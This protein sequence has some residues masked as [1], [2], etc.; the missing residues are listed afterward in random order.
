MKQIL[1]ALLLVFPVLAFGQMQYIDYGDWV[2][3]LNLVNDLTGLEYIFAENTDW[4]QIMEISKKYY[5]DSHWDLF[6]CNAQNLSKIEWVSNKSFE[7]LFR[8]LEYIRWDEF[9]SDWRYLYINWMRTDIKSPFTVK[10]I[11]TFNHL[12]INGDV[13]YLE[14]YQ[15]IE[16]YWSSLA[17]SIK[18]ILKI[19]WLNAENAKTIYPLDEVAPRFHHILIDDNYLYYKSEK[20]ANSNPSAIKQLNRTESKKYSDNEDVYT[21]GINIFSQNALFVGSTDLQKTIDDAT[22]EVVNTTEQTTE[23]GTAIGDQIL[24]SS[25]AV[26]TITSETTPLYRTAIIIAIIAIIAWTLVWVTKR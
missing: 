5:Y 3:D 13:Y 12:V 6:F 21:D 19:E 9:A 11:N 17:P 22:E 20:V 25:D 16:Q 8:N 14:R 7:I 18:N 2:C 26:E 4:S 1:T 10:E 24:Q 23:T 15:P